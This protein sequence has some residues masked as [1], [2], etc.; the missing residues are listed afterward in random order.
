MVIRLPQR[1]LAVARDSANSQRL[2]VLAKWLSENGEPVHG[3]VTVTRMGVGY[4]NSTWLMV[5]QAGRQWVLRERGGSD[6]RLFD[7]EATVMTALWG[8]GLPVPRVI[9]H[10]NRSSRP[11][12]VTHLVAGAVITDEHHASHL[13]VGQRRMLSESVID[14]LARFHAVAPAAVGLPSFRSGHL[15]RQL[16]AMSDL[17]MSLGTSS[18]H[19]SAWRAVR[20]RI[21]TCRPSGEPK[22]RVLH[23]DYRLANFVAQNDQIAAVLDW[24][25]CTAGDPLADLAWLLNSWPGQDW[26]RGCSPRLAPPGGFATQEEL[27]DLYAA[28]VSSINLQDLNFQRAMAYWTSATLL[29]AAAARGR[30]DASR[31]PL[32]EVGDEIN[33]SLIEAASM[34][35][36]SAW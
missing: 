24:E 15:D 18:I 25:R 35:K 2:R 20:T 12:M 23:G 8:L 5:D 19:D 29:Q 33:A 3:P 9:G 22:V 17:W 36:E 7:R 31:Q 27:V 34:L 16:V 21:L 1:P 30:A 26:P 14:T 28:K 10:D 13:D 32:G 6:R 11:F 4:T